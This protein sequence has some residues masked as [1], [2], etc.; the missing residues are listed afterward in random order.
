MLLRVR[1]PESPFQTVQPR[2]VGLQVPCRSPKGHLWPGQAASA[3]MRVE[4]AGTTVKVAI[5]A[6]SRGPAPDGEF[7]GDV[8]RCSAEALRSACGNG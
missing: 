5:P 2:Q 4:T 3:E 6:G 1:A 8:G 7:G